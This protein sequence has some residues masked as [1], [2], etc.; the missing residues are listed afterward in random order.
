MKRSKLDQ[1]LDLLCVELGFCLSP[2]EHARL[3]SSPPSSV[4]AFTDAVFVAE[5]LDPVTADRH[6]WR[7]VRDRVHWY[8]NEVEPGSAA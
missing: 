2:A 4:K 5:G 8:I 3:A 6:L 7:Q 1:L